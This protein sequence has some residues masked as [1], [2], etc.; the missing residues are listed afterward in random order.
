MKNYLRLVRIEN[1]IIIA[2]TQFFVYINIILP[3]RFESEKTPFL[4]I[5]ELFCIILAT[6]FIAAAGNV[7]NDYFDMRI[8]RINKPNKMVLGKHIKRRVAILLNIIFN[9]LGVLFGFL[10]SYLIGRFSLGLIFISMTFLML[11]YSSTLKKRFLSG[12]LL[13]A[14]LSAFVPVIVGIYENIG[15]NAVSNEKIIILALV[16]GVFAFVI[17]FVREISKDLEDIYGDE[18]CGCTTLA[19]TLGSEKTKNIIVF[20]IWFISLIIA[21]TTGVIAY[22]HWWNLAMYSILFVLLPLI[23]IGKKT[24][25]SVSKEDFHFVSSLFKWVML[26]GILSTFILKNYLN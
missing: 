14:L 16:Y 25:K 6:I 13:V 20:V 18:I 26:T 22:L 24:S 12:N 21:T 4:T 8:D 10:A 3:I 11:F 15:L 7:I 19:V 5:V 17:S 1:L 23:F 9:A 2:I